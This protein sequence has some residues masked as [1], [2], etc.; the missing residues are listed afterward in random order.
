VSFKS[1]P[2][3]EKPIVL[4]SVPEVAAMLGYN[5]FYLYELIREGRFPVVRMGTRTLRVSE[6]SLRDYMKASEA[7]KPRAIIDRKQ[8]R[9]QKGKGV[10]TK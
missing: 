3:E 8:K 1:K 10:P 6:E 2:A 7:V 4:F 5:K 9:S